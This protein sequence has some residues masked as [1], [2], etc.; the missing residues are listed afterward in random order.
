VDTTGD[1]IEPV[2][3]A[4]PGLGARLSARIPEWAVIGAITLVAGFVRF[5]RLSVPHAIIPLDET[6]Y[7]KDAAAY[8]RHGV[9]GGFA[10]H[11]P[12]G[13]WMIAAGIKIF[14]DRPFGWRASAALIGTLSILIVYLI[15]KRLWKSRFAAVSASIF[16]ATDGL[17]F[18]Q[19][20]VAMLDIFLAFF[21]ILSFWCLIEDRARTALD[22]HGRRW[23][24]IGAGVSIGLAG[25]TKWSAAFLLPVLIAIFLVFEIRRLKPGK[26]WMLRLISFG[27][28]GL[29]AASL[30]LIDSSP[31]RVAAGIFLVLFVLVWITGEAREASVRR[32]A[33]APSP[34][35]TA[36]EE[37]L[38]VRVTRPRFPSP[39]TRQVAAI[40]A[41]FVVL[42]M[43]IYVASYTPWFLSTKRYAP[44]RCHEP[45]SVSSSGEA[46]KGLKFWICYQNEIWTYHKTLK[47]LKADG[48]PVHPY[49]S[50]AWSWPWIGR[51]AA[52]YYKPTHIGFKEVDAEII[53]LPN[54]AM[55]WAAF[56]I[57]IPLLLW[58]SGLGR[59][60]I[61]IARRLPVLR[62]RLGSRAPP[63][64]DA[65][66]V[67]ILL[68]LAPL[69]L[70]WLV[71]ARPLFTFYMTPAVPFLALGL[72]HVIH[73]MIT[74]WPFSTAV[75]G[76]Y[77]ALAVMVFAYFYPVLAALPIPHDGLLGWK[78]HMW[79][80]SD[81]TSRNIKT[82][83]WI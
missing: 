7:A 77:V 61:W 47:S 55:W 19:S 68:M 60:V 10:V 18:V 32:A 81:C 5:W 28:I 64:I 82:L 17:F 74:R 2:A 46:F 63:L 27:A 76:A 11:P 4:E 24:R 54:P 40:T 72:T 67:L 3:L 73:R 48:T 59:I 33:A 71:T 1:L 53:G 69:Y 15:A 51:P 26:M 14:G 25:A 29:L 56:F 44:P 80:Q 52:H 22:H 43:V 83:C 31:L 20:R 21:V 30:F 58:W 57:G 38:T 35:V 8:L 62:G 13:K 36:L 75:A 9:E 66:A 49:M 23:W 65:P 41:T 79:F 70:P 37:Q 78:A 16:V 42:P 39:A 6:Y 34:D 45:V 50:H 12:V